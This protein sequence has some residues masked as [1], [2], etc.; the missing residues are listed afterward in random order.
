VAVGTGARAAPWLDSGLNASG[1]PLRR[2]RLD[3]ASWLALGSLLVGG[4]VTATVSLS[5]HLHFAY[6]KPVLHAGLETAECLVALL[7]AYLV[8]GRCRRTRRVNDV[9]LAVALSTLAAA[10]LAFGAVPALL[11]EGRPG[12]VISWAGLGARLLGAILFAA[13]A[14]SPRRPVRS[15][16]LEAGAAAGGAAVLLALIVTVVWSL[17]DKL[18]PVA[19]PEA[20]ESLA[21]PQLVGHPALVVMQ[22]TAMFAYALAAGGFSHRAERR[23]EDDLLRW[24][25]AGA[26]FATFAWVNYL[27]DPT[28]YSEWLYTGDLLR[29]LFYVMLLIG[30]LR[31]INEYWR[32]T[33]ML[34]A[35]D[36]RR[37]LARD[38]HDGLAQEVAYISRATR[39]LRHNIDEDVADRI[40]A[41]A[42]RALQ[43]SRQVIA[44]LAAPTEPLEAVLARVAYESAARYGADVELDVAAGVHLDPARTEALVRIAGEAVTNAA[45]HSGAQ[46]VRVVVRWR[47]ARP[48]LQV[49]DAGIG[50][51]PELVTGRGFGLTS[52]RERAAAV[53]A[54]LHIESRPGAGTRLEAAF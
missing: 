33:A 44:A 40:E 41:A 48:W 4:V 27:L 8:V 21:N 6:R 22:L 42:M 25:G 15:M 49:S 12:A 35:L 17:R 37:R 2:R 24:L 10:H 46:R 19:R 54:D 47:R 34:A 16:K 50:F 53:G 5:T 31:E 51:E 18:P 7:V 45:R 9:L 28:L 30:A 14:L 36:E 39:L 32:R 3:A 13:A 1:A 43:E 52:M 38:L 23:R 29:F 11:A 20:P 26:V